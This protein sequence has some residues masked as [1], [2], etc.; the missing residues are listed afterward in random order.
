[1]AFQTFSDCRDS[2]SRF[3]SIEHWAVT[4]GEQATSFSSP[5]ASAFTDADQIVATDDTEAR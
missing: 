3:R 4:G 1:V 2:P 5:P